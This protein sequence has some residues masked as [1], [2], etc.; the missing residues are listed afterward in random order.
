M[1]LTQLPFAP[2]LLLFVALI[3]A[4]VSQDTIWLEASVSFA[5]GTRKLTSLL[6]HIIRRGK[7]CLLAILPP[8]GQVPRAKMGCFD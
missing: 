7:M 2:N 4:G 1:L 3:L 5:R 8:T 6:G